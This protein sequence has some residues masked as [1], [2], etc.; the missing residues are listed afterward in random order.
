MIEFELPNLGA[1]IDEGTLLEWKVK[2]GDRVNKG[3]VVAIVDT[4]KAAVD[5]E[6]WHEGTVFELLVE[7]DTVMLVGTVMALLLEPGESTEQAIQWKR[8]HTP[9]RVR[10]AAPIAVP[11]S[12]V[13]GASA[14]TAQLSTQRRRISPAARKRADELGIELEKVI[15]T[16][17]DNAVTI[18]DVEK[19]GQAAPT[20]APRKDKSAEMR[21]IIAAAMARAKRDIPH[22]YLAEDIA[23][24][25][26]IEWL[27]S[28]NASRT[29]H[30]R[31]LMA[32]LYLKAVA[33]ALGQFSELN[34]FWKDQGFVA[35]SGI[36][37][38]V[39]ISLR[40]GG[41]IAPA[42]HDVDKKDLDTLMRELA[43]LVKRTRA[44][45]LKSSE[46]AD[47][48]I[49]IT[50][51]GDQGVET[52][53]GVI[54]P[55]QVALVGF[56]RVRS[57]PW[58]IEQRLQIAPVVTTSLSADHR[59][60]DGHRGGLFLTAVRDFLQTPEKLAAKDGSS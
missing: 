14:D 10:T 34:G 49:T 7:P 58:V 43:D 24:T 28:N 19:A 52:V 51:L 44:G 15:G 26:A 42:I 29:I 30:E 11:V 35:G 53:F 33:L 6:S 55:P 37:V 39:A 38:G 50:N 23:L 60:S 5:V 56:G 57:R 9:R 32:P 54:Y 47:P 22:Y 20:T 8:T 2:A 48:T 40:Q 46:L 1:D 25:Q 36:H 45:S 41:L 59:V 13:R 3:D 12:A 31:L 17:P 18:A 16:G 21:R 4:A 27:T